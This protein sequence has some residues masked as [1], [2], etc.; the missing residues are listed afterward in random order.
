M[1]DEASR[2]QREHSIE[3][4]R[5][6]RASTNGV[7][8]L[9]NKIACRRLRRLVRICADLT[10]SFRERPEQAAIA[11]SGPRVAGLVTAVPDI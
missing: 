4:A 9:S 5:I 2:G 1:I 11:L 8:A 6:D 10:L 3:I 7:C